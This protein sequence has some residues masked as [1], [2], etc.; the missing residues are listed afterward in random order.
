MKKC[1]KSCSCHAK[2]SSDPPWYMPPHERSLQTR[3]VQGFLQ[4]QK[5]EELLRCKGQKRQTRMRKPSKNPKCEHTVWEASG[6]SGY[7]LTQKVSFLRSVSGEAWLRHDLSVPSS[8]SH[9][10]TGLKIQR[11]GL[12]LTLANRTFLLLHT[13]W[14]NQRKQS[15]STRHV[16][17]LGQCIE[18]MN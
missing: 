8:F 7:S 6:K 2:W 17:H 5:V 18:K 15:Q 9:C 13:H 16:P 3:F 10:V 11:H 4:K 14:M 1:P 12:L